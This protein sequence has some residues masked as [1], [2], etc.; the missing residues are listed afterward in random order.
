MI[1]PLRLNS[2]PNF[3]NFYR[4]NTFT[5]SRVRGFVFRLRRLLGH[6]LSFKWTIFF[7]LGSSTTSESSNPK[8][9]STVLRR[10]AEGEVDCGWGAI[11]NDFVRQILIC[12]FV[13]VSVPKIRNSTPEIQK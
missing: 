6:G 2:N 9:D 1:C 4:V 3:T 10:A 12:L 8:Q 5:L 7:S 11:G 13:L